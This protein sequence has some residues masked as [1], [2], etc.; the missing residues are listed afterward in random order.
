[1]NGVDPGGSRNPRET[2]QIVNPINTNVDMFL[3]NKNVSSDNNSDMDMD[4]LSSGTSNKTVKEKVKLVK[5]DLSDF[6]KNIV[7]CWE[8]ESTF[9]M[10]TPLWGI[11]QMNTRKIQCKVCTKFFLIKA[12]LKAEPKYDNGTLKIESAVTIYTAE[13]NTGVKNIRP[14]VSCKTM[15]ELTTIPIE[16]FSSEEWFICKCG[17][18]Q[19]ALIEF[20]PEGSKSPSATRRVR[21]KK[22]RESRVMKNIEASR[23]LQAPSAYAPIGHQAPVHAQR[24]RPQISTSARIP[25]TVQQAPPT[26][27]VRERDSGYLYVPTQSKDSENAQG[28]TTKISTRS[29]G[30]VQSMPDAWITPR[31]ARPAPIADGL[32]S[33]SNTNAQVSQGGV[34]QFRI[35]VTNQFE[36][37]QTENRGAKRKRTGVYNCT[38]LSQRNTHIPNIRIR[39]E[40]ATK[41][42]DTLKKIRD[43]VAKNSSTLNVI[44]SQIKINPDSATARE[45]ILTTLNACGITRVVAPKPKADRQPATRIVL[46]ND[47]YGEDSD[48]IANE[49]VDCIG[50]KPTAIKPLG[51]AGKIH[52]LI[53]DGKH[54]SREILECFKTSD[55][56]FFCA[57]SIKVEPF[58]ENPSHIVQCKKYYAFDHSKQSCYGKQEE[59]Q[60]LITT[61]EGTTTKV[62]KNCKAEDHGANNVKCPVFK[63]MIARQMEQAKA[64]QTKIEERIKRS[65]VRLGVR[66]ADVTNM[67]LFPT[68]SQKKQPQLSTEQAPPTTSGLTLEGL[69]QMQMQMQQTLL[70]LIDTINKTHPHLNG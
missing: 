10:D 19:C 14:C 13:L 15:K 61:P 27:A 57:P 69:Y 5:V 1:M 65:V 54:K 23:T 63:N 50:I 9:Q 40:N 67:R 51:R 66:Y 55:R 68:L 36:V 49:I 70:R 47:T 3:E 22:S 39:D 7:Q 35:P 60:I 11:N 32:T 16:T 20:T 56:K 2:P 21:K 28:Q 59:P 6:N 48:T 44:G 29:A 42:Q 43:T 41:N 8:C 58:K 45:N 30:T 18:N 26:G 52:L 25:S 64:K 31:P 37:L 17:K 46:K 34:S 38:T 53:F 62:C 33:Y 24:V 12:S 4:P